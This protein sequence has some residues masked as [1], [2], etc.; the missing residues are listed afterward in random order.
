[1]KTKNIKAEIVDLESIQFDPDNARFHSDENLELIEQSVKDLGFARSIVIDE[2]DQM[3]AGEGATRGAVAAGLKR[4]IIIDAEGD[5]VIAVRRKNLTAEQKAKLK[6]V[7]NRANEL[8][9]WDN[10]RLQKFLA[11]NSEN[12][13]ATGFDKDYLEHL[14]AVLKAQEPPSLEDLE[15]EHGAADDS[16]VFS[17]KFEITL[18]LPTFKKLTAF[19]E[20]IEGETDEDKALK[21]IEK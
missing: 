20:L 6:I 9:S 7:D 1:M 18:S 2:N 11:D 5:E 4:A 21:L 15:N 13:T 14:T 12:L 3:I 19:W 17:K 10:S 16:G 8:S